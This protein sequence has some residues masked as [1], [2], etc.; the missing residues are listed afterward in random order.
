MLVHPIS[1]SL[2]APSCADIPPTEE[3][4]GCC[5]WVLGVNEEGTFGVGARLR[6]C[7]CWQVPTP[8]EPLIL[9]LIKGFIDDTDLS[10]KLR[11]LYEA[12][13]TPHP[14]D[15]SQVKKL[16]MAWVFDSKV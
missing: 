11:S 8:L 5:C 6:V 13:P 9:G 2:S 7:T 16:T 3:H 15:T 12:S 14:T 4:S 1:C 10:K